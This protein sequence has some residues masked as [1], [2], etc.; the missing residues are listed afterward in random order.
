MAKIGIKQAFIGNIYG[1]GQVKMFSS[2][3]YVLTRHAL[4]EASR[5]GVG[6]MMFNAPG[7]S[8]SGGPWIKPE[9]SM[10]R[11]DWSEIEAKGGHFSQVVRPADK[12]NIQDVAVLAIPRKASVSIKGSVPPDQDDDLSL[13]SS[14]WIWHPDEDGAKTAAVGTKYFRRVIQV[15]VS[16]LNAARMIVSADNSYTLWINGKKWDRAKKESQL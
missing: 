11:I 5:V 1:G 2:E 6:I 10:R 7:W 13:S 3:W 12:T 14:S 15:D 8:Q 9:Q 4:K 16:N